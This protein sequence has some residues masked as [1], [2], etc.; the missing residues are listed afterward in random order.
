MAATA[1]RMADVAFI[2]G[3]IGGVAASVVGEGVA[4]PM[5]AV[6]SSAEKAASKLS[7]SL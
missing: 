2:I 1:G 4:W 6:C 3:T 7:W 5:I